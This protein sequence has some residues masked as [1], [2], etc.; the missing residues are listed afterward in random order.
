MKLAKKG[1]PKDPMICYNGISKWVRFVIKT[2]K[3]YRLVHL[4][5]KTVTDI[6]G[7]HQ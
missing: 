5:Y 3:L 4:N 6:D 1:Y 7:K 2:K